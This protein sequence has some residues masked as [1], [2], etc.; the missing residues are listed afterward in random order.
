MGPLI[1]FDIIDPGW[2]NVIAL[3][4]GIAFGFIL[5]NSGFSSSRKLAGVFYGY[6]FVVLKVFFTAAITSALGLYYFHY[7]GWID[8][9]VVYINPA[10]ITSTIVGG[11]IMGLGFV[12]GGYCPGTSYCG[13]AIGKVDAIVF[14]FAM[15]F[16]I[17]AFSEFYPL[18]ADFYNASYMGRI[19]VHE[20]L[21]I[22]AGW[23]MLILIIVALGAFYVADIIQR[24]VNKKINLQEIDKNE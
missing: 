18:L 5:E 16:G 7:M 11:V 1:P 14:S 17:F 22:P 15:F 6:D 4:I 20:A 19:T 13:A 23:F 2:N 21:G 8:M 10:Y 12:M 24:N 9:S 3:L